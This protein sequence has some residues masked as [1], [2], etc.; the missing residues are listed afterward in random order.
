M[1]DDDKQQQQQQQQQQ[2]QQ[3]KEE[4]QELLTFFDNT[5][6]SSQPAVLS[7]D[8]LLHNLS[9]T[10]SPKKIF[11][12][13]VPHI[14]H[15]DPK[16]QQ[17]AET[18]FVSIIS[19]KPLWLSDA[20]TVM[21]SYVRSLTQEKGL[22]SSDSGIK[23]ESSRM[24]HC[25]IFYP[26]TLK[27]MISQMS[28]TSV[29]IAD[30]F[31]TTLETLCLLQPD[32]ITDTV[33]DMLSSTLSSTSSS[34]LSSPMAMPDDA[35]LMIRYY[36][37]YF[38]IISAPTIKNN[39]NA[40]YQNVL[41]KPFLKALENDQDPLLQ[42][43]LLEILEQTSSMREDFFQNWCEPELDRAL[44]KMVGQ[45]VVPTQQHPCKKVQI[46]STGSGIGGSGGDFH[47][48]CS[49]AALRL[50]AIREHYQFLDRNDFVQV[51]MDYG[52]RNASAGEVEKIGFI[53]GITTFCCHFDNSDD[54]SNRNSNVDLILQNQ[55][56]LNEWLTLRMG[57]SKLKA[58]VM[59]S[60]ARV[61][62]VKELLHSSRLELYQM[63][64]KVNDVGRGE[65]TTQI[66]MQYVKG[67]VVELRLAAYGILTAVANVRMGAHMLMKFGGFFEFLCN[68]NLEIVKEGKELK[69]GL[70]MAVWNSEVKG[71]LADDIVRALEQVVLDGPFYVKQVRDVALE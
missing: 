51:L 7:V 66:I 33:L 69:Y 36:T 4:I 26:S 1:T 8:T 65:D 63:I 20:A 35:T 57:Q 38:K 43:G 11:E 5:T 59:N 45:Q 50:L 2:K 18:L 47:P 6:A 49:G 17:A 19:H 22:D 54:N 16:H 28:H 56:L 12:S 9:T 42:M 34:S 10:C 70:V 29:S 14:F 37:L 32:E 48:F 46:Q 31:S 60:V 64:G 27:L 30:L 40:K 58:V 44:L 62:E 24:I 23:E 61:L 15:K 39:V 52:G 53:D 3:E 55:E 71:L 13:I 21:L 25:I 68:R 67:Q 41:M